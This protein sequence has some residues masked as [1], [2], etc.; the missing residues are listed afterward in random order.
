V[1]DLL[2]NL[3]PGVPGLLIGALTTV[4][5]AIYF[6]LRGRRLKEPSWDVRTVTL[7]RDYRTRLPGLEVGYQGEPVES[8]AVTRLLL[9]NAGNETI[10][11]SDLDSISPI[12]VVARNGVQIIDV[13][14]ISDNLDERGQLVE[15][16]GSVHIETEPSADGWLIKSPYLEP[17]KGAVLQVVH[18]AADP[19]T[20]V[21]SPIS[22]DGSVIG[23]RPVKRRR[24]AQPPI[25]Q[26]LDRLVRTDP[27]T[28]EIGNLV[29]GV[30]AILV[31]LATA[32]FFLLPA[33]PPASAPSDTAPNM[34]GAA[35]FGIGG[36]A[37]VLEGG[38]LRWLVHER[39]PRGLEAFG[40]RDPLA[41]PD[42]M[43]PRRDRRRIGGR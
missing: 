34:M 24:V 4:A 38:A 30:G 14:A 39:V 20:A 17:G 43:R 12:R 19:T 9:W 40:E 42:E 23:A 27:T 35:I 22:V 11:A 1:D 7:I 8:L 31:L 16:G 3:A 26:I 5:V 13:F 21:G 6:Y 28:G 25:G 29:I 41:F 36:V 33:R 37:V 2:R 32:C 10:L 18:T 15:G